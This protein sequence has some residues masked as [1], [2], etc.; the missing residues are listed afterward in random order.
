RGQKPIVEVAR[1]RTRE[2]DA[3]D[4][5]DAVDRLDQAGE[6]AA[7]IVRRLVVVDDLPE[8][9]HLAMPR[10]GRL[11]DLRQNVVLRAHP[12]VPARVGDDAEAAE[13]VAPFD[14]R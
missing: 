13:L 4:T 3:V 7:G 10:R 14:D 11:G 6:V 9:L 12:L 5:G 2:A 8:Q 1:M